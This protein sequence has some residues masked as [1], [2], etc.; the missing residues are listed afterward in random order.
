MNFIENWKYLSD[1]QT[2]ISVASQR[3]TLDFYNLLC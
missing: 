3:R 2:I 1:F